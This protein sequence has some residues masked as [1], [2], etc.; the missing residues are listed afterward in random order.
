MGH[1]IFDWNVQYVLGKIMTRATRY[2]CFKKNL[3][4]FIGSYKLQIS[5]HNVSQFRKSILELLWILAILMQDTWRIMYYIRR[6][7]VVTPPVSKF[8]EFMMSLT[9]KCGLISMQMHSPPSFLGAFSYI[10]ELKLV[11]SY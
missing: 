8:C 10:H 4:Y 6:E 3:N 9:Q 1:T 2:S 7:E 5:K 11:D